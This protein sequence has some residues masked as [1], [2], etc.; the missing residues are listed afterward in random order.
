MLLNAPSL[1]EIG[2]GWRELTPN[3][4][5][6]DLC[7]MLKNTTDYRR[8]SPRI[9]PLHVQGYTSMNVVRREI[10]QIFTGMHLPHEGVAQGGSVESG[11]VGG[12]EG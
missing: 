6:L 8:L 4:C 12:C 10:A 11:W 7:M 2:Q 9:E 3:S 5:F 1:V